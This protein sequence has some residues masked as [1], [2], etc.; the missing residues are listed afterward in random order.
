VISCAPV[1]LFVYN[2]PWHTRQTVEA[3]LANIEAADTPLYIFSDAPKDT[4]AS[5]A[6]V[7]VRSFLREISGFKSVSIIERENN[8]GLARSVIDGVS[9]VCKQH[10]Q[11]IVLEDD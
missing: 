10:G 7:E 4:E 5:N 1:A 3:L 6:V 8:Y 2:R 9:L 11:V